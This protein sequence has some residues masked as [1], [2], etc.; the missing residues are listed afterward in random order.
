[1]YLTFKDYQSLGGK[2]TI[3]DFTRHEFAA[4]KAIDFLTFQRLQ[5][6]DL[7]PEEL[8]MCVLELIERGYC[9]ALDG[10][11][12]ISL[13]EGSL[14]ASYES[15]KGKASEIIRKYLDGLTVQGIPVFYAGS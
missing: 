9:G 10:R 11:E 14:S 2:L 15:N 7:I 5:G 12:A 6:I 4:R 3:A 1:M 8:K 13:S